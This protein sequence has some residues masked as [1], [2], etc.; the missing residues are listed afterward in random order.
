M[1]VVL[2]YP[3]LTYPLFF[4][5]YRPRV[6]SHVFSSACRLF[7]SPKKVNSFAIKQIQ[8]LFRKHPG[9][10]YPCADLG[11][12][13]LS[14]LCAALL[15]P[16][17]VFSAACRLLVSLGPLFRAP[18]VCFQQLAASFPKNRGVGMG[19]TMTSRIP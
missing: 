12:R 11:A 10:G 14:A 4:T 3:L 17:H 8:A 15:P 7:V 16:S 5:S 13:N 9:W 1:C 19:A 18:L 6:T 2:P